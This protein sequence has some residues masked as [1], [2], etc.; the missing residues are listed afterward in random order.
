MNNNDIKRGF[1]IEGFNPLFFISVIIIKSIKYKFI[2]RG[3]RQ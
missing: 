3:T 1:K 2:K